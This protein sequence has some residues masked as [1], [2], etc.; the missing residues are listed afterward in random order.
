MSMINGMC[1][2]LEK[3]Q[4]RGKPISFPNPTYV[5]QCGNAATR[6]AALPHRIGGHPEKLVVV[7]DAEKPLAAARELLGAIT[8]RVGT[9]SETDGDNIVIDS[10]SSLP[11]LIDSHVLI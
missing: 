4:I 6:F 5:G 8:V 11:A 7:D 9:P 3:T 10:L 2:L 1:L